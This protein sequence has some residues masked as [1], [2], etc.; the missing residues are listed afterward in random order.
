M[1]SLA[2]L[3]TEL[4]SLKNISEKPEQNHLAAENIKL[5]YLLESKETIIGIL[6]DEIKHLRE[7]NKNLF[8][9]KINLAYRG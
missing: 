1:G 3:N 8:W 2:K 6:R 7:E 9:V 5:N 4:E